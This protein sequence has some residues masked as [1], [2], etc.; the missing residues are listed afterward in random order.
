[1]KKFVRYWVVRGNR[2]L[3]HTMTTL[4]QISTMPGDVEDDA[5]SSSCF[6]YRQYAVPPPLTDE[7]I[8][9][10]LIGAFH[11][12]GLVLSRGKTIRCV[13]DE[14]PWGPIAS[15]LQWQ[16]RENYEGVIDKYIF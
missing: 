1:M 14:L 12:H 11:E 5:S 7:S 10:H 9:M 3:Y 13:I 4:G 8:R 6:A 16:F 15:I 2:G